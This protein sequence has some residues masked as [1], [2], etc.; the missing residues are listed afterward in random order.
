MAGSLLATF[1]VYG[2]AFVIAFVAGMFP[3]ASIEV[4]LGLVTALGHVAPVQIIIACLLGALGH[5]IAK[6]ACYF[7]GTG[8]LE[9]GKLAAKIEKVRP[10][11]ERWNRRPLLVLFLAS[12][13]GLPP[14]YVIAFIAHPLM[15]IRFWTF[16]AVCFTGRVGR[17]AVVAFAPLL[18]K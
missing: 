16:T 10:R 13:I 12:T 1:G 4:F 6:T 7:A 2:G 9:R 5:Q 14:M 18:W 15:R 17:Y 3:V 8:A 11:I